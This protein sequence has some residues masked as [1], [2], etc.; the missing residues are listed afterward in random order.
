MK[1]SSAWFVRTIGLSIHIILG[2]RIFKYLVLHRQI[3]DAFFGTSYCRTG[4]A[5]PGL[6]AGG[7]PPSVPRAGAG[8][9]PGSATPATETTA[10]AE[11]SLP[12]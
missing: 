3:F 2:H 12:E 8:S 9:G 5:T 11:S 6:P 7:S 10:T 4:S 1:L